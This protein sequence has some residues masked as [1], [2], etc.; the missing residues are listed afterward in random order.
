MTKIEKFFNGVQTVPEHK[1]SLV[2]PFMGFIGNQN[3]Q[4][5][6][7]KK[8]KIHLLGV[9]DILAVNSGILQIVKTPCSPKTN[10]VEFMAN[11]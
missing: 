9:N 7:R 2:P 11:N 6:F 1:Y 10:S 5:T 3:E 4:L 8:H